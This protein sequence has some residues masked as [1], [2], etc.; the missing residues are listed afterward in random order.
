MGGF[1]SIWVDNLWVKYPLDGSTLVIRNL[2]SAAEYY[3]VSLSKNK[4]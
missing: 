3:T 2:S 4:C 1:H